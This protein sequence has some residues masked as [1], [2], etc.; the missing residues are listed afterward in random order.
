[1]D[2]QITNGPHDKPPIGE[3]HDPLGNI[4]PVWSDAPTDIL[5][6]V[7]QAAG[8]PPPPPTD[9]VGGD[10]ISTT[11]AGPNG[12]DVQTWTIDP[13]PGQQLTFKAQLYNTSVQ[14]YTARLN[15]LMQGVQAMLGKDAPAKPAK[16]APKVSSKSPAP[17]TARKSKEK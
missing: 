8:N 11:V 14:A 10:L 2:V 17:K 1:V 12:A 15:A 4:I 7:M 9:D 5:D 6:A 3:L 16:A 13:L